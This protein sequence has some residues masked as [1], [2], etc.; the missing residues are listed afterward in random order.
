MTQ[1][2]DGRQLFGRNTDIDRGADMSAYGYAAAVG[3][4]TWLLRLRE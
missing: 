1:L 4:H 2:D 3:P